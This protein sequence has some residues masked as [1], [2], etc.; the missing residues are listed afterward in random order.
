MTCDRSVPT[1]GRMYQEVFYDPGEAL[2][3]DWGGCGHLKIGGPRAGS[4]CS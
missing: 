2:Q 4:R 1:R 3:V